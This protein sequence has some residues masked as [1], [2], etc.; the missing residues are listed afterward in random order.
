MLSTRL[1]GQPSYISDLLKPVSETHN[2][3]LRSVTYGSL[4]DVKCCVTRYNEKKYRH[5]FCRSE[6]FIFIITNLNILYIILSRTKFWTCVYK[7]RQYWANYRLRCVAETYALTSKCH[8]PCYAKHHIR[9]G[10][11]LVKKLSF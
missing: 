8:V 7:I 6:K 2:R 5:S 3:N 9:I 1:S 10:P 4:S 11:I